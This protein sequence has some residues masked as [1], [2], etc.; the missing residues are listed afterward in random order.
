MSAFALYNLEHSLGG[1]PEQSSGHKPAFGTVRV[2]RINASG[3]VVALGWFCVS[4]RTPGEVLRMRRSDRHQRRRYFVHEARSMI[5]PASVRRTEN[6]PP[7][8]AIRPS[9]CASPAGRSVSSQ[10]RAALSLGRTAFDRRNRIW[11]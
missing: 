8:V 5:P 9:T 3:A 6:V 4:G 11:I 7:D 2:P 1:S 10:P